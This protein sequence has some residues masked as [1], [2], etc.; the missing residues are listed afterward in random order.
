M[1]QRND[2]INTD[3]RAAGDFFRPFRTWWFEEPEMFEP[4]I[5]RG[6]D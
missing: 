3:T 2:D 1:E 6:V 5:V 4:V